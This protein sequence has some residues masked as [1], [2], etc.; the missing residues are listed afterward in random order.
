M[1]RKVHG[2]HR[3]SFLQFGGMVS[4]STNA[5]LAVFFLLMIKHNYTE[6][7][8][9]AWAHKSQ[10]II[11]IISFG[12]ACVPLFQN[13]YHAS[14][15]VCWI[16]ADPRGCRESWDL[17]TDMDEKNCTAGDY[18]AFYGLALQVAPVVLFVF[19]DAY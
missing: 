3:A 15:P 19:I 16:A 4:L 14:G 10:A 5:S 11:W 2:Q 18:A 8:L 17:P 1:A 6:G 13:M 7:K 9:K 12:I